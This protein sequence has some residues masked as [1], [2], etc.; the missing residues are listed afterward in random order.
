MCT[1]A[2]AEFI[3]L[4]GTIVSLATLLGYLSWA[5]APSSSQ[6][7]PMHPSSCPWGRWMSYQ[8]HPYPS[9]PCGLPDLVCPKPTLAV[10]RYYPIVSPW[11]LP[12]KMS[13]G[14]NHWMWPSHLQWKCS[15]CGYYHLQHQQGHLWRWVC[16][17]WCYHYWD[18]CSGEWPKQLFMSRN[19][20]LFV[21]SL[22]FRSGCC[23]LF[24]FCFLMKIWSHCKSCRSL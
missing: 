23:T 12:N 3:V 8:K 15:M 17:P 18:N 2:S 19:V 14:Y 1:F 21:I 9:S 11:L 7:M 16:V 6:V 10:D 13:W 4:T 5:N 24:G 20:V 22:H